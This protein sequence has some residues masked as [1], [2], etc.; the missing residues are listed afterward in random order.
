L[1]AASGSPAVATAGA[2]V[3]VFL[4]GDVMTGRAIDQILPSPAD[5]VLFEPFVRD[6]RV[7]IDL[8]EEAGATIPRPVL[9]RYIWGDALAIWD[10]MRPAA[11]VVNLE[12]SI[13]RSDEHWPSKEVLYRMS[14]DNVGCLVE[15]GISVCTLA[16]N[17]VL[18]W[19]Y[20]GLS[21]TLATLDKVGI[22]HPGAGRD[23]KEASAH[24]PIDL[25]GGKR[26]L[27]R[28]CAASSSGVPQS[29]AAGADC[30][31]V[32]LLPD[33]SRSTAE[34]LVAAIAPHRLPGDLAIV[35][36][37]WGSNWG[38]AISPDQQGFARHLLDSGA[39][40]AVHGHSS[41]HVMGIEV[42][43]G[44]L[45]LYGCGDLL[46]DYEG[47]TGHGEF[48]GDLGLMYFPAFSPVDGTLVELRM[49]P[50]R[51]KDFRLGRA[52][53]ADV[54]WLAELLAREGRALNTGVKVGEDGSLSLVWDSR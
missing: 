5:P 17:H 3:V 7:Y 14:P 43:R 37:H 27:L 46:N 22:R 19:G 54:H 1:D 21:E 13:T 35:S 15:A 30:P 23:S 26:L 20:P 12:T 11:R 36:I 29:W 51:I 10:E 42:Y 44:K 40:D 2:P 32:D 25:R 50:T 4:C 9:P 53:T 39:V 41:H 34:F 45:I 49:F 33:L 48:R 8:A 47:I 31:G 16:N 38:Y 52:A 18:D 28:S 24:A 6:A